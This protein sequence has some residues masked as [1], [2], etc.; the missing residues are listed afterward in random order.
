MQTLENELSAAQEEIRRLKDAADKQRDVFRSVYP[1]TSAIPS[2]IL[3]GP[4]DFQVHHSYIT[5][6]ILGKDKDGSSAWSSVF[7]ADIF[8]N[9]V[10][11]VEVT[12]LSVD[13]NCGGVNIGLMD[14]SSPLPEVG[15]PLGDEVENSV[16]LNVNG[17]LTIG[18]P[19]MF[20][21]GPCHSEL[22]EGDCVR[23]EV[24]LDSTPRTVRFFVNG[25]TVERYISGIHSSVR[26]KFSL[27]GEGTSIRIDNISR[28]P[29]PTPLS[30]G[31]RE[32]SIQQQK[33]RLQLGLVPNPFP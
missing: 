19:L 18:I 30:E 29:R 24:D 9:G 13:Y 20:A 15:Q 23:M 25:E 28:L 5:R 17:H 1:A 11:S 32:Y 33:I 4:S 10:I 8:T 22:K 21:S 3:T 12:L 2:I 31:M 14:Y 16:N 26:I 6:T 27:F 7:L